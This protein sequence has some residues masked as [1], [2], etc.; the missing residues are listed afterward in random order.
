VG[1]AEADA[2]AVVGEIGEAGR[3]PGGKGMAC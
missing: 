1:N 3:G 2:D